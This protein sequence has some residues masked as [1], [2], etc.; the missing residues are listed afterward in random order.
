MLFGHT[1]SHLIEKSTKKCFFVVVLL[2]I[3]SP[4]AEWIIIIISA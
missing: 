2:L 1:S 4:R 3:Q